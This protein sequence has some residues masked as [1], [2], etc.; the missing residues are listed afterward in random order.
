MR[1]QGAVIKEQGVKFAIVVVKSLVLQ[2]RFTANGAL[3]K[4]GGLFPG[5]PIIIMAQ[6]NRGTPKY[7]GRRDIVRF[8]SKV[9]L[10]AIP[11]RQYTL[12]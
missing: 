2:N 4:F 8:M 12:R 5:M 10:N 9:P 1:V 3:Q 6:N 7:Y 11:W